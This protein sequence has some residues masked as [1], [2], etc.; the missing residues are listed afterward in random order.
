MD[1]FTRQLI[2]NVS[3]AV[4]KGRSSAGRSLAHVGFQIANGAKARS[5][6]DTGRLR[7]SY[8]SRVT[9]NSVEVATT[10][11]YAAHQEFG[12]RHQRGTPHLRPAVESVKPKIGPIIAEAWAQAQQ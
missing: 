9:G 3:G 4:A 6:V 5:P 1:D 2:G 10:V 11:E 8:T 7:S 12:T